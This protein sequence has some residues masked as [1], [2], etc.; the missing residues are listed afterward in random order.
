MPRA[1]KFLR[2]STY[3]L[4]GS[5]LLK[6]FQIKSSFSDNSAKPLFIR[7][8][9]SR[10]RSNDFTGKGKSMIRPSPISDRYSQKDDKPPTFCSC[11]TQLTSTA[12]PD[13]TKYFK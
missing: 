9:A 5:T 12:R 8:A 13:E 11:K 1:K 4:G 3:G 7:F 2:S 10:A 6:R